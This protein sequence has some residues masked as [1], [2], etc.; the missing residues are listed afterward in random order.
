M[1]ITCF[2]ILICDTKHSYIILQLWEKLNQMAENV[3]FTFC[4]K[5]SFVA[6]ETI[7]CLFLK[8]IIMYFGIV[9]FKLDRLST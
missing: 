5:K 8:H 7:K 1:Y 4:I 6:M 2:F 9:S 3:T